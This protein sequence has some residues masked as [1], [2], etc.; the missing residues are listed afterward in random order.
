MATNITS[1]FTAPEDILAAQQQQNLLRQAAIS[2]QG[3]QFGV[4]APLYQAGLRNIDTASQA[5]FPTQDPRLQR[6]TMIQGVLSK[7][8][9]QDMTD[10]D[11]LGQMS[12]EFAG[13]G[14]SR[15]AMTLA[16]DARTARKEAA[17]E[18][19]A[20]ASDV[21]AEE[22][23]RI[24]KEAAQDA[25]YKSNPELM[26]EDAR[27]LP[28]DDPRKQALINQYYKIKSDQQTAEAQAKATL[29][30][31]KAQTARLNAIAEKERKVLSLTP[32]Q[33]AVDAKF[34]TEYNAFVNAGGASTVNKLLADLDKVETALASGSNITGKRVGLQD[35]TGT[36][37]YINPEAQT[38]K[39]LAGGVIQ[40]N[41]RSILGGQFAQ[42]EGAELLA[43]AYNPAAPQEDNL[44]R[45]RELKKQIR[46]ALDAKIEAATFYEE[47]GTLANYKGTKF[48]LKPF[49]ETSATGTA[50]GGGQ[51]GEWKLID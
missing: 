5:L 15:E 11:V 43:R 12:S 28:D 45:I 4:F 40:S 44:R 30:Q 25:R 48:V 21:R 42:K 33:K 16:Q 22:S 13:M 31:T 24:Q 19:R 8:Q 2:Q 36:L 26:I 29:E 1:L 10:P 39:D 37:A 49:S 38:A 23:L 32:A 47:N 9:D 50:G 51:T 27:K 46:S 20:A 34:A 18:K 41:L 3:S 14:L 7:Y 17:I 35:A 6:A